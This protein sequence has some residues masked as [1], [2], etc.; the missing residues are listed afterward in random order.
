MHL[1]G[2]VVLIRN[3]DSSVFHSLTTKFA[4]FFY[5][6]SVAS[7]EVCCDVRLL[8]EWCIWLDWV[9]SLL[10]VD[11]VGDYCNEIILASSW[12]IRYRAFEPT[13]RHYV[14]CIHACI[15]EASTKHRSSLA[16]DAVNL[17]ESSAWNGSP[18]I[19]IR[20]EPSKL[21]TWSESI[22]EAVLEVQ[23]LYGCCK[24]SPCYDC[25]LLFRR[26]R[27]DISNLIDASDSVRAKARRRDLLEPVE[28][29][30]DSSKLNTIKQRKLLMLYSLPSI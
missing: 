24:S 4:I 27:F 9:P 10:I 17:V 20:R 1:D 5:R 13:G 26:Y 2:S 8:L 18:V 7:L 30:T 15:H 22:A 28:C 11:G 12:K 14:V 19:A 16:P 3:D 29:G 23:S 21:R 25:C 6:P